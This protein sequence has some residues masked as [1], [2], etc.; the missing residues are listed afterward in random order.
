METR[1]KEEMEGKETECLD[2]IQ[3]HYVLR[4]EV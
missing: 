1:G 4:K 3:I 2:S